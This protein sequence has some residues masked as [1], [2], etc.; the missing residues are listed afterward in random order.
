[1]KK[2][3][4]IAFGLLSI[5]FCMQAIAQ[6]AVT[7]VVVVNP[8]T[9]VKV[10]NTDAFADVLKNTSFNAFQQ[11][12]IG[13]WSKLDEK[14]PI[15][16]KS[17][18]DKFQSAEKVKKSLDNNVL[19]TALNPQFFL[20]QKLDD[21]SAKA[22][23]TLSS[24]TSGEFSVESLLGPTQ[25]DENQQKAAEK[26]INYVISLTSPI[27]NNMIVLKD[28]FKIS[29]KTDGNDTI[30]NLSQG[31]EL[32][33]KYGYSLGSLVNDL[34]NDNEYQNAMLSNYKI[35]LAMRTLFLSTIISLYAKRVGTKT[36]NSA[37]KIDYDSASSRLK[38]DYTDFVS[39]A[40]PTTLQRETLVV[41]SQISSQLRDISQNQERLLL[42]QSVTGLQGIAMS[43][44][45]SSAKDT[46]SRIIYCKLPPYKDTAACKK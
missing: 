9:P 28:K 38:K 17:N 42:L 13:Y 1:M 37:T 5:N 8:Q 36:E 45:G 43:G 27:A 20:A 34:R 29:Y 44:S 18:D 46:I 16:Q 6:Q 21:D 12:L 33:S 11:F 23:Y 25:Y 35:P 31:G 14:L 4:F 32:Q 10:M 2:I 7:P 39:K 19:N 22:L 26:Y 24:G 41:L 3:V 15:W 30:V 40:D